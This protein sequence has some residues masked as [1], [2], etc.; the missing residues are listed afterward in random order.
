MGL[1]LYGWVVDASI[2]DK[3]LTPQ[4]IYVNGRFVRD[5]FL[6]HALR[7]AYEVAEA[8]WCRS[9][10]LFLEINN[11]DVD[12]NVHPTKHEVRFTQPRRIHDFLVSVL[13]HVLQKQPEAPKTE[14][15]SD[16]L[17]PHTYT[18]RSKQLLQLPWHNHGIN[19]KIIPVA[20]HL[21]RR[22]AQNKHKPHGWGL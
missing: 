19:I 5:R 9:Y 16:E 7:Q 21:H 17:E 4:Y 22:P 3:Q 1:K 12:V 18:S 6:S 20:L 2:G 15:V 14:P 10:V 8:D 11:S 13:L